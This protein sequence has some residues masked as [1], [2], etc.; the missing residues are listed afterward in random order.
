MDLTTDN[1]FIFITRRL[2]QSNKKLDSSPLQ[3][4]PSPPKLPSKSEVLNYFQGLIINNSGISNLIYNSIDPLINNCFHNLQYLSMTNNFIRNL[5]F[6][7]K[8]PNLFYFDAYNNPIEELNSLNNRNIFGYMR[9]SIERFNEKKILNVVGLRCGVF[10]LDLNNKSILKIFKNNN[11]EICVFN[12]EVN[13]FIDK[14][15][16]DDKKKISKQKL[17]KENRSSEVSL[18]SY[19]SNNTNE[20]KFDEHSS[21][22]LLSLNNLSSNHNACCEELI[23]EEPIIKI[24]TLNP[25]LLKIQKYFIEYKKIILR[26]LNV[27]SEK[28]NP[29]ENNNNSPRRSEFILRKNT[30]NVVN[31]KKFLED[32]DYLEIEKKKLLLVF[33]IYKKISFYNNNK[34]NLKYYIG[35]INSINQNNNLDFIFIKEIKDYI[36]NRRL[37]IRASLIILTTLF[38]YLMSTISNKMMST[39]IKYI[40]SKY[41]KYK[42]NNNVKNFDYSNMGNIH[43]LCFYYNT[44]DYIESEIMNDKYNYN[45]DRY[46]E[47]LTILKMDKIILKSN[48]LYKKL[49]D[50]L[51][52]I[53][54]PF[55]WKN[56]KDD[57]VN[58]I[59]S[60]NKELNIRKEFLILIEF[61]HDYIIFE[62]IEQL[63]IDNTSSD[64]YSYLVGLKESLEESEL[65]KCNN[66]EFRSLSIVKFQKNQKERIFN[67][68]YFKQ[69]KIKSIKN[70]DFNCEIEKVNTIN[71]NNYI[72]NNVNKSLLYN[73]DDEY[74][75]TDDLDDVDQ[76]LV[77]DKLSCSNKNIN[78]N[79]VRKNE[80]SE[81]DCFQGSTYYNNSR[82]A[83]YLLKLPNINQTKS[84]FGEFE[85][86]KKMII[87]PDFLSQHARN[88]LKFEKTQ[89]K[90]KNLRLIKRGTSIKKQKE[91]MMKIFQPKDNNEN[92]LLENS[93]INNDLRLRTIKT[94][95]TNNFREIMNY[96]STTSN[97]NIKSN[98]NRTKFATSLIETDNVETKNSF[99]KEE[100]KICYKMRNNFKSP[101]KE[102]PE[103][104]PAM[105]LLKFGL[106]KKKKNLKMR[107][108]LND[109]KSVSINI[110]KNESDH[111]TSK[112]KLKLKIRQLPSEN[113]MKNAQRTV[114]MSK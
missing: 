79:N 36:N 13:Y 77:I 11:P 92:K 54:Q 108:K 27:N 25:D 57:I 17:K 66:E 5:N 114:Y 50:S 89:K 101:F 35:N 16:F 9:L 83:N 113:A 53:K 78:N 30:F 20:N 86:F 69:D 65:K 100:G 1:L 4:T 109:K 95:G 44:Y 103:S 37:C 81:N 32:K 105:T 75:K 102:I 56:K 68:F 98:M 71:N 73:Q 26:L 3:R 2:K 90:I 107:N 10:D 63:L 61:L 106:P 67:K 91:K 85:I 49:N 48:F 72:Y 19:N 46:K 14:L 21:N 97:M 38:F 33:E 88:V 22:K 43:F 31:S 42:E 111:I 70:R 82:S 12:S 51:N 18:M 59:R 76:F 39:L 87:D 47:I 55:Y 96:N 93:N 80:E 24:E 8:L 15:K 62:K 110:I 74:N 23:S 84:C 6:L 45:I 40:L 60:L 28:E 7:E 64:E 34:N 104:Y 52:N 58:E 99:N 94:K 41:F 112:Q 29:G